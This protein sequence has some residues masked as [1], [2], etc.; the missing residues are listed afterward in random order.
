MLSVQNIPVLSIQNVPVRNFEAA[1]CLRAMLEFDGAP[2]V[3]VELT[4]DDGT[5]VAL[6]ST[7]APHGYARGLAVLATTWSS[8]PSWEAEVADAQADML[9]PHRVVVDIETRN[10]IREALWSANIAAANKPD[11]GQR[12][13]LRI[14]PQQ[15][16]R[17]VTQPPDPT[18]GSAPTE[19]TPVK[20]DHDGGDE[21]DT[22]PQLAA[23]ID[24]AKTDAQRATEFMRTVVQHIRNARDQRTSARS[25]S[26]EPEHHDAFDGWK[27][28]R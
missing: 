13:L 7:Y 8:I 16:F 23:D 4:L 15:P 1:R 14:E 6:V 11:R 9:H 22:R 20:V 2:T 10:R 21:S 26:P 18:T 3:A 24:A 5:L 25:P 17:G 27:P 12:K 28:A 19:P